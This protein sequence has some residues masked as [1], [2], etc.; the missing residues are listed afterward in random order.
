MAILS[1]E[2][3]GAEGIPVS[4][5]NADDEAF[6]VSSLDPAIAELE[7]ELQQARLELAEYQTLLQ[8]LPAIYEE[9]FRQK[10]RS[11]AQDIRHLLDER[12]ALQETLSTSLARP[13]ELERLVS[14]VDVPNETSPRR[15]FKVS[16][17]AFLAISRLDHLPY[18]CRHWRLVLVVAVVLGG[19]SLISRS[20]PRLQRSTAIQ[21]PAKSAVSPTPSV[22]MLL[23]RGGQSWV[24]LEDQRGRQI[25]DVVLNDGERRSI[26][27]G[28]GLRIRSGRPDLLYLGVDSQALK[29]LGDVNDLDWVEIRPQP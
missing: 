3:G 16:L 14:A 12:R 17:P 10:V 18:F 8:D 22:L 13:P 11:T 4:R 9:K 25:L 23:A 19:F 1:S 26:N 6:D 24:L 27:I 7:G 2:P 5:S 21:N 28:S 29:V 20:I 15:S